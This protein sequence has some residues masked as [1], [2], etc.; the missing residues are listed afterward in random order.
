MVRALKC[1]EE[2]DLGR[3]VGCWS[4][5]EAYIIVAQSVYENNIAA[6]V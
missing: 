2:K 3:M 6:V 1:E 5:E 4:A